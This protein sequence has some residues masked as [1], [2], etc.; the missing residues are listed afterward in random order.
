MIEAE[1][2]STGPQDPEAFVQERVGVRDVVKRLEHADDVE[3]LGL[4][5]TRPHQVADHVRADRRIGTGDGGGTRLDAGDLRV[6]LGERF[7]EDEAVAAADLQ[8]RSLARTQ[9]IELRQVAAV[10]LAQVAHLLAVVEAGL[11]VELGLDRGIG[12]RVGSHQAAGGA[13]ND[14]VVDAVGQAARGKGLRVEGFLGELGGI[15]LDGI[16]RRVADRTLGRAQLEALHR[17]I[18]HGLVAAAD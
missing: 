16:V 15:E 5:E 18:F 11:C 1:Q 8:Q 14:P 12:D 6:T 9:P 7:L 3:L 10:G 2:K 17:I 13:A 4:E